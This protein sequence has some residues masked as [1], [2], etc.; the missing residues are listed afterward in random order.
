MEHKEKGKQCAAQ[1]PILEG[2][3]VKWVDHANY[4]YIVINDLVLTAAT[5]ELIPALSKIP[6]YIAI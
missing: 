2:H 1:F 5:E 4:T 6:A 3:I